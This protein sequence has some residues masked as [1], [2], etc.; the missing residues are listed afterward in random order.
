MRTIR[1]VCR[2]AG[3]AGALLLC[4]LASASAQAVDVRQACTPDAMRLCNE[5][6]PDEGK[7]KSC[8]MAKRAQLSVECR[9]AMAG[10]RAVGG[11]RTVHYV[12][13][14][15]HHRGS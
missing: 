11:R 9:S 6:I 10:G 15:R 1:L 8:M 5:F 13:H 7:V 4:G 3:P 2:L 12:Y 14:G